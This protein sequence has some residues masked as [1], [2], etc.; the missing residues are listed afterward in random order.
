MLLKILNMLQKYIKLDNILK[1]NI[2][3]YKIL[4]K[5]I[6]IDLK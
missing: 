6:Y 5:I 3:S 1:Y 2:K 4:S